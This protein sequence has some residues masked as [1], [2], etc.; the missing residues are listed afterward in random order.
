MKIPFFVSLSII[1]LGITIFYCCIS[2]SKVIK[3][4][5][6]KCDFDF[7]INSYKCQVCEDVL[8]YR[9]LLENQIYGSKY[10][11]KIVGPKYGKNQIKIL[12]NQIKP[13]LHIPGICLSKNINILIDTNLKLIDILKKRRLLK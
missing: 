7:D 12:R 5:C 13:Y 9:Y 6:E 2:K 3:K 8:N 10:M 11:S 1:S 4:R